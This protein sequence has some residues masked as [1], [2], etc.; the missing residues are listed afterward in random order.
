MNYQAT[1]HFLVLRMICPYNYVLLMALIFKFYLPFPCTGI[2][3]GRLVSFPKLSAGRCP[4]LSPAQ[5]LKSGE[6]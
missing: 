5:A 6:M 4:L 1:Q 2:F 3:G